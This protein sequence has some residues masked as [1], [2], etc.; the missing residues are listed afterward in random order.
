MD[1][2][3][4]VFDNDKLYGVEDLDE[5]NRRMDSLFKESEERKIN[6]SQTTPRTLNQRKTAIQTVLERHGLS[7]SFQLEEFV[8]LDIGKGSGKIDSQDIIAMNERVRF[9]H[10]RD[11]LD[12]RSTREQ[13]HKRK[14][15]QTSDR[16]LDG[17]NFALE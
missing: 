8:D 4:S 15:K 17:K 6:Y 10:Y 9:Q 3:S 11:I 5:I 2:N 7:Q 13:D 12:N 16:N 14:R 1:Y